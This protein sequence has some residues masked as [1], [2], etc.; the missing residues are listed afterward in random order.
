MSSVTEL[1]QAL[2]QFKEH[3]QVTGVGS[4]GTVLVLTRKAYDAGLPLE[5]KSLLT[6]SGSQVAGLNGR[7][8][9]KILRSHD[10]VQSVGTESG[11]TSRG[12]PKLAKAY[13]SF[14]GSLAVSKDGL[15]AIETWWVHRFIDYFNTEPFKLNYDGKTIVTVIHNL[16]EQAVS[17]QRKS[18][19]R[20][21]VGTM[22]QH[23]VG[24]KLELALPSLNIKHNGASVADV[25]SSRSGDFVIDGSVIHCT[26][27]PTEALIQKCQA[28]LQAGYNPI[29]LTIGKMIGA[30][31]TLAENAGINGRVEVMDAPQFVAGNLY[32]LSLFKTS[33]RKAIL[34]ELVEKYNA[35]VKVHEA[36]PSLRITFD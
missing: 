33:A 28:N 31:E 15:R 14:L 29:I 30:A 24:A 32:E 10:V 17:R 20:T 13:A 5:E 18:P 6:P 21:Y 7:K 35:I 23:L 8:I 34:V 9:N 26:T 22:L 27:A 16:L 36:D 2:G 12:T 3:H 11:R 25:V 19:G 1:E 4:L